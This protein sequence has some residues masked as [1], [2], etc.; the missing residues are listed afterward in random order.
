MMI[1]RAGGE[2]EEEEE[3]MCK[4]WKWKD[5]NSMRFFFMAS[6]DIFIQELVVR[7]CETGLSTTLRVE[8]QRGGYT[9][10]E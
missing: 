10:L 2:G 6:L 9:P 8:N 5:E 4:D 7:G 3:R 1:S